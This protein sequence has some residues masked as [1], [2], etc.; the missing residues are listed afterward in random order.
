MSN[1][2]AKQFAANTLTTINAELDAIEGW[3]IDSPEENEIAAE[4]LKEVKRR[5]K[6]LESKRKEITVPMNKALGAVNELFRVPRQALEQGER[7]LKSKIADYLERVEKANQAKLMAA[8]A[9]ESPED[10]S[11]QLAAVVDTAP[12]KGVSVRHVWRATVTNAGAVPRGFMVPDVKAI[13]AWANKGKTEAPPEL[14]GVAFERVP[15]V[16]ARS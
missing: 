6:E 14:A 12:P 9:A 10:A 5:H 2:L 3:T 13:E 16:S 15:I 11:E 7:I 1:A 8:A 4:H